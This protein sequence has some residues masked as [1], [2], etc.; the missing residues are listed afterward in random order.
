MPGIINWDELW[1]AVHPGGFHHNGDPAAYWDKKAKA[2]NQR[3]MKHREWAEM[4]VASLKLQPHETVL[5]IGAGTGRLA[6][7]MARMAKSVTALDRSGGMLKCLKANMQAEGIS[8][9]TCIQRDWEEIG[10]DEI[11][12]HDVVLSSNSLGVVDLRTALAKMDQLAKRAVYIFTFTDHR[13]DGGFM[14]FLM[15]E[16][17][18]RS[19][20]WPADY[21]IIY[22][23]LA[24]MGIHADISIHRFESSEY[25]ANLDDAVASWKEMHDISDEKVPKLREF[26]SQ[27]LI[28]TDQGLQMHRRSKIARISWQKDMQFEV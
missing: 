19:P 12:P 16:H 26:L 7:P 15:P 28:P 1:K 13:R 20:S 8:N 11:P 23:L 6:I 10:V 4:Q 9:I 5:D 21:L 17:S 3:V 27:K 24:D 25:Y 18:R 14:E 2:F 22:N